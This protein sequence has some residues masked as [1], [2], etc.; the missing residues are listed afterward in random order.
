MPGD[1]PG[2]PVAV[3]GEQGD[4]RRL[5]EIHPQLAADTVA[6]PGAP[7]PQGIGSVVLAMPPGEAREAA[8]RRCLGEP[9]ANCA[10]VYPEEL[11]MH[12]PPGNERA[13][14]GRLRSRNDRP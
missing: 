7:L 14:H 5:F 12:N 6:K 2:D 10:I 8:A 1:P 11:A 9:G 3:M 13:Q 4:V